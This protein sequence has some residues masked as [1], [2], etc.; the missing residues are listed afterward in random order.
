METEKDNGLGVQNLPNDTI[1]VRLLK[2]KLTGCEYP[3]SAGKALFVVSSEKSLNAEDALFSF[4]E[5]S[6][7]IPIDGTGVN[8]E[9]INGLAIGGGLLLRELTDDAALARA[10][11]LNEV[12]TVGPVAFAARTL[13]AS[14][15]DA[16]TLYQSDAPT[17]AAAPATQRVKRWS[18]LLLMVLGLATLAAAVWFGSR[19]NQRREMV[20]LA[21]RLGDEPG[22]YHLLPGRD[23]FIYILAGN[24]RDVLWARQS[25]VRSTSQQQVKTVG[26]GDESQRIRRWLAREYPSLHVHQ[27]LFDDPSAP[28]VR[29]SRQRGSMSGPAQSNLHEQLMAQ[30]PYAASIAITQIDDDQVSGEAEAGLKKLAVNYTRINHPDHVTFVVDGAI[31]D[32]DL[33]RLRIFLQE[34]EQ[35]WNGRYVQFTV[36]MLDDFLKGKSYQFGPQGYVKMTTGHWFFPNR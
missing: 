32:G 7:Y 14:W 25:L 24:E 31:N 28:V 9:I 35:R 36:E 27:L 17:P 20:S 16:I 18:L 21:S 12:V 11:P 1:I 6:I 5:D 23:G 10:L 13:D 22:K 15:S 26:I 4:P 30:L 2:G 33:Q 29:L 19:D 3:I 8:F 34:Y